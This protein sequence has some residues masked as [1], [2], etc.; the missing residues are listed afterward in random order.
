MKAPC[1]IICRIDI[2]CK[3]ADYCPYWR[4]YIHALKE[5]R[6]ESVMKCPKCHRNMERKEAPNNVYYY[7][8]PSCHYDVGKPKEAEENG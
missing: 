5:A 1:K 8:C 7:E 6:G 4:A 3:L 2:L